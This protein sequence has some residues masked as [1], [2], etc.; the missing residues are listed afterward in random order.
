MRDPTTCWI[1]V[2]LFNTS[3]NPTTVTWVSEGSLVGGCYPTLVMIYECLDSNKHEGKHHGLF[4]W[5]LN[6]FIF[7]SPF[8]LMVSKPWRHSSEKDSLLLLFSES[9]TNLWKRK[10]T[11]YKVEKHSLGFPVGK[12]TRTALLPHQSNNNMDFLSYRWTPSA[13]LLLHCHSS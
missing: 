7:T 10:Q 5:C 4:G 9:E 1:V 3:Y 2:R 8:K 11:P 12:R 13:F 6:S